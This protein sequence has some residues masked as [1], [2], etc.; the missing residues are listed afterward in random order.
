MTDQKHPESNHESQ[1]PVVG[2]RAI[3][4]GATVA[5]PT[6]LTLYS[7]SALARSSNLITTSAVAPPTNN[8]YNCL[9]TTDLNTTGVSHQYDLGVPA[10]GNVAR[11][12]TTTEY[13]TY[14]D[15]SAGS[16][17]TPQQMCDTG[18]RFERKLSNGG[19]DTVSVPRGG[20][21]SAT[22]LNSLAGNHISYNDF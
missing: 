4:R 15:H 3:L 18:G 6:L 14:G 19:W 11:I 16:K 8:K 22:A 7:G 10:R 2:R 21:V 13:H 9:S 12:G 5:A 1:K 17:V 20:M